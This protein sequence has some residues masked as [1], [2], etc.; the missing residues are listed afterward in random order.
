MRR[1]VH[2]AFL[3]MM[4]AA[5]IHRREGDPRRPRRIQIDV[6]EEDGVLEQH[7]ADLHPPFPTAAELHDILQIPPA[8]SCIN[9]GRPLHPDLEEIVHRQ[10]PEMKWHTQR[11]MDEVITQRPPLSPVRL[12]DGRWVSDDSTT[13]ERR[14]TADN[15][16]PGGSPGFPC[17]PLPDPLPPTPEEEM[18]PWDDPMIMSTEELAEL[19]GL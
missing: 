14:Y 15:E 10:T 12:I 4:V 16:H 7:V 11:V 6:N 9:D 2:A 17:L 18:A 19:V 13:P 8:P 3:S 1:R 5:S